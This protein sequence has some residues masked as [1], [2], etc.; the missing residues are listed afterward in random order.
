MSAS[1]VLNKRIYHVCQINSISNAPIKVNEL[2][3]IM[4]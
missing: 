2:P 3:Q 1:N 4:H